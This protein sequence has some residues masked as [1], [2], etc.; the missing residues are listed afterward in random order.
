M[1]AASKLNRAKKKHASE[2][3]LGFKSTPLNP[4]PA[5]KHARLRI[6][7]PL[8]KHASE[9]LPPSPPPPQKYTRLQ[10]LTPPPKHASEYYRPCQ[11]T[12]LNLNSTAKTRLRFS[13]P[14]R[15]TR[16]LCKKKTRLIN[17][18]TTGRS[19][20][21][22]ASRSERPFPFLRGSPKTPPPQKKEKIPS[23]P[24][25][26][27]NCKHRLEQEGETLPSLPVG[28]SPPP[29]ETPFRP[30]HLRYPPPFPFPFLF[31]FSPIQSRP[32]IT[33][34]ASNTL[35]PLSSDG[36]RAL[37]FTPHPYLS[38]KNGRDFSSISA[39][40]ACMRTRGCPGVEGN[41]TGYGP[42]VLVRCFSESAFAPADAGSGFQGKRVKK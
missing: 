8:K 13:S 33:A 1:G 25:P 39:R 12:P 26:S 6:I 21:L 2:S 22:T 19:T 35:H 23:A 30:P 5:E 32:P 11:N 41:I 38:D 16:L 40:H 42:S 10:T 4:N 14:A 20:S 36:E 17:G 9:S 18:S 34:A 29:F 31:A 28:T 27:I 37:S 7:T 24:T 3:S 15:K